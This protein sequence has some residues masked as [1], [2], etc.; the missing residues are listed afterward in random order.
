MA[1]REV[2]ERRHGTHRLRHPRAGELE[3]CFEKMPLP[4]V[5]EQTL[6]TYTAEPGSLSDGR[7]RPV[8][9]AEAFAS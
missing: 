3:P 6:L 5:P 1:A 2:R 9:G 7:L 4:G 8:A